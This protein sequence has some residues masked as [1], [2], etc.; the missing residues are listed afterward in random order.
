MR[1]NIKGRELDLYNVHM[2]AKD[3]PDALAKRR[4][5][6]EQLLD[7]IRRNSGGRTIIIFGDFNSRWTRDGDNLE[8]FRAYGFKDAWAEVLRNGDYPGK[9]WPISCP[10]PQFTGFDCEVVDKALYLDGANLGLRPVTYE[11]KQD[12]FADHLPMVVT[13]DF[14]LTQWGC[15]AGPNKVGDVFI[16]WGHQA[17]DAAWKC[18]ADKIGGCN[19]ACS[20]RP[21]V[22]K[23]GCTRDGKVGDVTIGW[24]HEA[25]D[26]AW[27]CNAWNGRCGGQCGALSSWNCKKKSNGFIIS[28]V[29]LWY[30]HVEG[31]AAWACNAWAGKCDNDCV[32]VRKWVY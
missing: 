27:A 29:E 13:W 3:D 18:N 24:G 17:G 26:A 4:S 12:V 28:S 6:N 9:G 19:G 5:H 16:H 31:D 20:A 11:L 8:I 22:S 14:G 7:Y 25:S 10:F 32:A 2:G 21:A 15:Y 30:G 1:T 23:W